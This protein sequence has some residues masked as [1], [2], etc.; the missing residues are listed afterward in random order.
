M[1]LF[2]TIRGISGERRGARRGFGTYLARLSEWALILVAVCGVLGLSSTEVQAQTCYAV[3]GVNNWEDSSTWSGTP[4]GSGGTCNDGDNGYPDAAD[5]NAVV[6]GASG[7]TAVEITVDSSPSQLSVGFVDIIGNGNTA[8][9]RVDGAAADVREFQVTDLSILDADATLNLTQ[10]PAEV[11]LLVSGDI[12]NQGDFRPGSAEVSFNGGGA[13]QN[14]SGSFSDGGAADND[15]FADFEV[16][17]AARVN[18][19]DLVQVLGNMNILGQYGQGVSEPDTLVFGGADFAVTPSGSFFSAQI[20]FNNSNNTTASGEVFADVLITNGT[21][22]QLSNNFEINGL[23]TIDTNDELQILTGGSLTLNDDFVNNGTFSPG[24]QSVEFSGGTNDGG[25]DPSETT[26]TGTKTSDD[27]CEQD[28]RGSGTLNFGPVDIDGT[29]TR[30]VVSQGNQNPDTPVVSTL[31]IDPGNDDTNTSFVLDDTD[32]E[33]RGDLTNN[34]TFVAGGK[35][36]FF[37]GGVSQTITSST[38]ITFFELEINNTNSQGVQVAPGADIEVANQ[39]E[40]IQG[41]LTFQAGTPDTELRIN[42]ELRMTG[43]TLET[44]NADVI[45]VSSGPTEGYV[46][47]VDEGDDGTLDGSIVGDVIKQRE[48][49]GTENWYFLTSP[50]GTSTNDTFDDLLRQGRTGTNS[51]WLQ[52]FTGANAETS[53]P[54]VSNVRLYDDSQATTDDDAGWVSINSASDEMESGRG[55]AVFVFSNDDF[56]GPPEGFEKLI[57]SDVEPLFASSFDFGSLISVTDNDPN[58]TSGVV[59]ENEGWQALG[60]PYLATLEF[61][62]MTRTNLD[63]VVYVYDPQNDGYAAFSISTGSGT[64]AFFDFDDGNIAP[65]QAFLVKA[66]D[67]TSTGATF[68]LDIDDITNVQADTSDFFVKSTTELPP[69]VTFRVE[70]DEAR[71]ETQV[72]FVRDAEFGKDP[73]DAYALQK[74]ARF[75]QRPSVSLYT[76]LD[77]G[78]GIDINALPYG[79]TDEVVIPMAATA[80][81]C[82]NGAPFSSTATLTWPEVRSMPDTVGLAIRDT[83][84]DELVDLRTQ[85]EYTFEITSTEAC[86]QS[87]LRKSDGASMLAAPPAP[88]V[89]KHSTAKSGSGP[90]FEFIVTPNGALPVEL[91]GFTVAA[92]GDDAALLEWSTLSETN[93]A[94][95]YVEQK[96]DGRFQSVSSLIEGAGTTTE[97]QS[98]RYRVEDLEQG[99]T[100]T[101]RLRQVDVDGAKTYSEPVDVKIG[102]QE[103]YQ[104]E[105]YPNPV[106]NGEQ[107]TVR[108][109]V[110]ESQPVTI[111]LYNTLGQRVRTLYKD[112]PRVTGEFQNVNLDVNGLA[113]GVYFIRM[114]GESFATTQKLV[115][116]R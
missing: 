29:N 45:L 49:D 84:T 70:A 10:V 11:R 105:A 36:I 48:L 58:G 34:G 88:R 39:L 46:S 61:G 37:N 9:I 107:P 82:E 115:V 104:L 12:Q 87:T 40:I 98:Y 22:V 103:A 68:D 56:S 109:A 35:R 8:V 100:H 79:V 54:A 116:V 96:V 6:D 78:T 86:S 26:C 80:I 2:D 111:E 90:R 59:D 93:N 72:A 62:Q 106:A 71:A 77:D 20:K 24:T 14:I 41:G 60:N 108:F 83:H 89:V 94:G 31:V 19:N 15:S 44:A 51:L 55:Y 101:F 5:E 67:G 28:I 75:D 97:Q 63:D 92:D 1:M 66:T 21:L 43:S 112:T 74:F 13:F 18:P 69:L 95:F 4:G 47:Y 52:G 76:T 3:A 16:Q 73:G 30:A 32:L 81:G 102:I 42:N 7:F 33:V 85:D 64:G 57:D 65:Q 91:S 25:G 17:S 110:D 113:S 53:N 23:L 50:A 38:G 99:T 114:R 27:D